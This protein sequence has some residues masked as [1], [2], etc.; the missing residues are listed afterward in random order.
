MLRLLV[1]KGAEL[2]AVAVAHSQPLQNGPYAA[3]LRTAKAI[4]RDVAGQHTSM[5][6][7]L[8]AR[9]ALRC[10]GHLYLL[11]PSRYSAAVKR[12]GQGQ[13]LLRHDV[14]DSTSCW[15]AVVTGQSS[16]RCLK[17]AVASRL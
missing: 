1:L 3:A 8:A 15:Y 13:R 14:T 2:T 12:C 16:G 10:L 11:S 7:R 17:R 6:M 9:T 5:D 4:H